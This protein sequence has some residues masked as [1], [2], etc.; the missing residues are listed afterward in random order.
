[1]IG[2]VALPNDAS[3]ALQEKFGFRKVAHFHEVGFKLNRWVDVGYWR[4]L[5]L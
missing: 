3:V 4:L 2:G 1:M 5:M